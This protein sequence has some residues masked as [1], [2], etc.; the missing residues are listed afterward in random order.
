MTPTRRP[1]STDSASV[2]PAGSQGATAILNVWDFIG[3]SDCES[4]GASS[5]RSHDDVDGNSNGLPSECEFNLQVPSEYFDEPC[6]PVSTSGGTAA[7]FHVRYRNG[8]LPEGKEP[9]HYVGKDLSHA[10]DEIEFYDNLRLAIDQ[11][12][13]YSNFAEMTMDCPGVSRLICKNPKDSNMQVRFLL[14]LENLWNGYDKMRL[15]DVKV[16]PETSVCN[17]KGKTRLHAWKNASIDRRTNSVVEG[18]RLEGMECPPRALQ[19]RIESVNE[20]SQSRLRSKIVSGKAAKR[21]LLQ[22]LRAHEFLAAWADVSTMG[23]GAEQHSHGAIWLATEQVGQLLRVASDLPVPQQCIGSSIAMGLEVGTLQKQPRV[24]VKV[25]DW[26]RAE[27]SSVSHFESLT[28][29]EKK[30]RWKYWRQYVRALSRF[31]WELCRIATH[32]C[33]TCAWTAFVFE[34][35]IEPVSIARAFLMGKTVSEVRGVGLFQLPSTG[36]KGGSASIVLPLVAPKGVTSAPKGVVGHLHIHISASSVG[37]DRPGEG[38]VMIDVRGATQLPG[39][40]DTSGAA[41]ITIRVIR[42]ERV[43]DARM[44]GEKYRG[45]H[46]EPTPRGRAYA[47]NTAPG[48]IVAGTM[49]WESHCE[50]IGLGEEAG[51][52]KQ[53][54]LRNLPELLPMMNPESSFD[55][56][57][58]TSSP[59]REVRDHS[60]WPEMLPPTVGDQS[61]VESV[62]QVFSNHLVPWLD[63]AAESPTR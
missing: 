23:A 14:L 17:W 1:E 51:T 4:V 56:K 12:I 52:A 59:K 35:R 8:Q 24:L 26:G 10:H 21:F 57:L 25:F 42:F 53:R 33:C 55:P 27:L 62:A 36:I 16:G 44:H 39:D 2:Y 38:S 19:D 30:E 43:G 49:V 6:L 40:L 15:V 28:A 58:A 22:R 61:Q 29:E 7:F 18:F 60:P 37:R 20:G 11:D 48:K 31:Y 41:M 47:L 63:E 32:R 9:N 50:F 45:G 13:R 34:L 54:L 5:T 46:P 3:D